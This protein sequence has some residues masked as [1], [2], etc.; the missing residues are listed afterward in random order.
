MFGFKSKNLL[1]GIALGACL[2]FLFSC[3]IKTLADDINEGK[4]PEKIG[5]RIGSLPYYGNLSRD[6]T[7]N[8]IARLAKDYDSRLPLDFGEGLNVVKSSYD[9]STDV[10]TIYINMS[11]SNAFPNLETFREALNDPE[12]RDH[13]ERGLLQSSCGTSNDAQIM[14]ACL[15]N[16]LTIRAS[17]SFEGFP[18]RDIDLTEGSYCPPN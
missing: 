18:V 14:R 7:K 4:G 17:F 10:W 15:V 5:A 11:K 13:F 6:K 12:E 16:G 1:V 2:A 3:P 9:F 8:L